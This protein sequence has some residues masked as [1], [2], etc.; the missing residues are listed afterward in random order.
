MFYFFYLFRDYY[1]LDN[2]YL[3]RDMD[4]IRKRYVH[5]LYI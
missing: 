4:H 2:I 1:K 3:E 5:D